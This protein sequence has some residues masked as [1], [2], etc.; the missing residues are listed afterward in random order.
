VITV[1]ILIGPA[2]MLAG[3]NGPWRIDAHVPVRLAERQPGAHAAD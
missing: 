2:D 1:S 3:M